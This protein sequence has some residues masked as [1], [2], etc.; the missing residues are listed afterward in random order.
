MIDERK[1]SFAATT[2]QVFSSCATQD[3]LYRYSIIITTTMSTSIILTP[4]TE[5]TF[6]LSPNEDSSKCTMTLR[7]PGTTDE[8]LAFKVRSSGTFSTAK[9]ENAHDDLLFCPC[10]FVPVCVSNFIL[11]SS[12]YH[13]LPIQQQQHPLTYMTDCRSKR[14]SLAATWYDQ[15]RV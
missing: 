12:L 15:I 8:Y 1:K 5:L 11:Y 9:K 10:L 3:F 13:T 7:H 6:T 2:S 4:D 14:R